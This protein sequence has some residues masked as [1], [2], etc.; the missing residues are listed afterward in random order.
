LFVNRRHVDA[1]KLAAACRDIINSCAGLQLP[2]CWGD[3]KSAAAG[4][5]FVQ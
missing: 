5:L 3:G 1:N 2:K 4:W